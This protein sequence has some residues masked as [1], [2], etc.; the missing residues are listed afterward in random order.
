[1]EN[2]ATFVENSFNRNWTIELEGVKH[3]CNGFTINGHANIELEV[4]GF[5]NVV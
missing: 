2:N 1:M 3:E 5:Q 4:F